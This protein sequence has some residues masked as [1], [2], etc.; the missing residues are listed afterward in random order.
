MGDVVISWFEA[1]P[2]PPLP[3]FPSLQAQALNIA[4]LHF[5]DDPAALDR[6]S[7]D[8]KANV[9]GVWL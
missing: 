6:L 8:M 1:K 5:I 4:K 9:K 2:L 7:S 3:S